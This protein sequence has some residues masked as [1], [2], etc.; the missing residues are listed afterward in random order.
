M[1]VGNFILARDDENTKIVDL[2]KI[3]KADNNSFEV[4]CYGQTSE[5]MLTSKYLPVW[6]YK[7]KDNKDCVMLKSRKP[8]FK[9][10]T[11]WTW[12]ILAE[13]FST[14]DVV[15]GIELN[16]KGFLNTNSRQFV[17]GMSKRFNLKR[18]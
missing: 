13:D 2:G 5:N 14:L 8:R 12:T 17:K 15:R 7:N 4:T 16:S 6:T 18:F 1:S 10:T 9:G 11:P 3:T